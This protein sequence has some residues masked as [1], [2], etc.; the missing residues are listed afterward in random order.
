MFGNRCLI[1]LKR[2]NARE[3]GKGGNIVVERGAVNVGEGDADLVKEALN[4]C[5]L[6]G[7]GPLDVV[8]WNSAWCI[9]PLV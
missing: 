3:A 2:N 9:G 1:F 4:E 8:V 6:D 5:G 7:P